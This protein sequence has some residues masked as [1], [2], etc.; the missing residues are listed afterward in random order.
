MAA[1]N[2]AKIIKGL[3]TL[4]A[5][6]SPETFFFDFLKLYGIPNATIKKLS[7]PKSGRNVGI[8]EGDIGLTKQIYCRAIEAGDVDEELESLLREEVLQ[9]QKIRFVVVTDFKHLAAYDFKV[10]D[11]ISIT[12]DDLR[13]NFDFFLP[14]TGKYEKAL[15]YSNHPADVK[16]CEKMGRLYDI[17]KTLNH[18]EE[19]DLHSLNV[20]LTRLLFCF[21]AEDT[22]IFP[23]KSQMTDAMTALTEKN[24]SNLSA[25]YEKLFK[26]L[27]LPEDAD[28]RKAYST[29]LQ[30]FPYVNGGLFSESITIPELDVRARKLLI[31]IGRLT[32]DQISPVI[33]GS[34]FQSVMDPELRHE[35]GAHYTSEKNILKVIEPLFLDD[36]RTE[37]A[38]IKERKI[39]SLQLKELK[40]FQEKLAK[41]VC[42]DPA[43]GCG[44]F[45]VVSY[46]E[47]KLLELEAVE[48]RLA[49]E[50]GDDRNR[51]MFMDWKE[52]YS[53]VSISQFYGIEIEEFPVEIARVSMWLMEHVMN[54]RF[55]ELLG[56]VLPSIPLKDSAHV[57]CANSLT[58]KWESVA[59]SEELTYIFGNPPFSGSRT[60]TDAQKKEVVTIFKEVTGSGNLDFVTAWHGKAANLIHKHNQIRCAFVSTNSICQGEQV[61]P[62]WGYMFN[63]DCKI[64]FAHQTFNWK[65]EARGNAGVHCVI[66]GYSHR[67]VTSEKC[68]YKYENINGEPVRYLVKSINAYLIE[69]E[70]SVLIH[71]ERKALNEQIPAI[72]LGNQ[73][74]DDG[75]LIIEPEELES[76]NFEPLSLYIKNLMGSKEL[77]RNLPRYCLWLTNAPNEVL[78]IPIVKTRLK[79]C[80][81][82]RL[83]SKK[84][85]TQLAAQTPHL[86]QDRRYD[87]IPEQSIVVPCHSSE[88]RQYIPMKI[89][90]GNTVVSN[91]CYTVPNGGAYEFGLLTSR[92]HMV[93]MRAVCGRLKNDYRYARDLCYNTFPWPNVSEAKKQLI[94]G[95]AED[96][97]MTRENYP[98]KTL[99]EL[100]DPELMPEDLLRAH[101]AL[102]LAVDR[103]FKRTPFESDEERL[104]RLFELYGRIKK[105]DSTFSFDED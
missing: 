72:V 34:M 61:A 44:N 63:H 29:T 90:G 47:L 1:L 33:F 5:S 50:R 27:S 89:I 71:P 95:L 43:S 2:Q 57:V 77:I 70:D 59:P 96:V 18:Y 25:F 53:K 16:A 102:D 83:L 4:I 79:Q 54:V 78:N 87:D 22:G 15:E 6:I 20:F 21:F 31:E 58:T 39:K 49:I 55:G 17:I 75:N 74:S 103:L 84:K 93:W 64:D 65:N 46:R 104:T 68:L 24:G 41:V 37:L 73:P 42:L 91:A 14:L 62:L 8:K 23:I 81:S 101:K 100:Y 69:G 92:M 88:N 60:M 32:W 99:A 11:S 45:L 85:A 12:V 76:F 30:S 19:D 48:L 13:S 7:D 105:G 35:L 9:K 97:L 86:F 3:E 38:A 56:M 94:E 26:V 40:A 36:L 67:S 10:K 98:E 51:S 52:E 28:E 66:V 82:F 80:E